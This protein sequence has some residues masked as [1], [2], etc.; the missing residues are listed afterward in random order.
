MTRRATS[1]RPP[2]TSHSAIEETAFA[3]FEE[4]GFESTTMS[5]IADALGIGRRTLFRYYASKNDILWGQFDASLEGFAR[6]LNSM[7]A[8]LPTTA[9]V[10]EAIRHFNDFPEEAMPQHR[11]RM[12]LLL[13]TPALLAH[14]ELRYAAWRATIADFVARRTG[15]DPDD[16]LPTTMG[17][18]SLALSLSAYDQWLRHPDSSL[19]ENLRTVFSVHAEAYGS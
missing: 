16:A 10:A 7:P 14:S 3:L 18:V 8:D 15:T 11:R 9:A 4:H 1:G 2:S 19:G 5:D 17:R 12:S 6:T 13:T